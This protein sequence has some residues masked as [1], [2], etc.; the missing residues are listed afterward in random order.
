MAIYR[1]L[2]LF[3]SKAQKARR[4]AWEQGLVNQSFDDQIK[5]AQGYL[6]HQQHNM[7]AWEGK[8]PTDFAST[9][10]RAYVA[11]KT[12]FDEAKSTLDR[13]QGNKER[14]NAGMSNAELMNGGSRQSAGGALRAV[15]HE[16]KSGIVG[17]AGSSGQYRRGRGVYGGGRYDGGFKLS[18]TSQKNGLYGI[19][20]RE[21][22]QAASDDLDKLDEHIL[23]KKKEFREH[24]GD[25]ASGIVNTDELYFQ[26]RSNNTTPMNGAGRRAFGNSGQT[27]VM[28]GTEGVKEHQDKVIDFLKNRQGTED[29][30]QYQ[31][32][33][34]KE[35]A[36]AEA[37]ETAKREA[38]R[39]AEAKAKAEQEARLKAEQEAQR[40]AELE[41]KARAQAELEAKAKAEREARLKAEQEARARAEQEARL[42]EE[43]NR[44]QSQR[45]SIMSKPVVEVED[46]V[47]Q[48]EKKVPGFFKRNK[49]ALMIG[50]IAAA[51]LGGTAYGIHRRNRK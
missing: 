2:R 40:K 36:A 26:K 14:F 35:K 25:K 12:S 18:E 1:I 3:S 34:E 17:I 10:G 48:Q 39:Q 49:K 43:R 41:A 23:D 5:K 4:K 6:E 21:H 28:V 30:K 16:N 51:G 29:Y 42:A 45:G 37:E 22:L 27:T 24:L 44:L 47:K 8:V 11:D 46:V 9:N 7:K 33:L 31:T 38:Q 32:R 19:N 50:G 20:T 15:R 13:L